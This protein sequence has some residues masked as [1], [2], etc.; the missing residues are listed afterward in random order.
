MNFSFAHSIVQ[1]DFLDPFFS[2]LNLFL[3]EFLKRILLTPKANSIHL[4]F[5]LLTVYQVNFRIPSKDSPAIR[6]NIVS[7]SFALLILGPFRRERLLTDHVREEITGFEG[8]PCLGG[9]DFT[10][11]GRGCFAT[12]ITHISMIPEGRC[13]TLPFPYQLGILGATSFYNKDH[14]EV[15]LVLP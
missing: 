6:E 1:I 8:F 10:Q 15:S 13:G 5:L 14:A 2:L 3:F 4:L 9:A 11:R 12:T 7:N